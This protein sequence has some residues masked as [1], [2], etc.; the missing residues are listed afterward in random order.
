MSLT[1]MLER[2][3]FDGDRHPLE[4]EVKRQGHNLITLDIL[5]ESRLVDWRNKI[6]AGPVLLHSSI[7]YCKQILQRDHHPGAIASFANFECQ[8][9][10]AHWGSDRY[11]NSSYQILPL[12]ELS[13]RVMNPG[14][15]NSQLFMRTVGSNKGLS[16][17]VYKSEEVANLAYFQRK[18]CIDD[19]SML[20]LFDRVRSIKAEWRLIVSGNDILT[21]SLYKREGEP[22]YEAGY[23]EGVSQLAKHFLAE[24]WQP[25]P[26]YTL[27]ICQS[28]G[29]YWLME[30]NAFSCSALYDC[31]PAPVVERASQIALDIYGELNEQTT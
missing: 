4:D 18:Y 17:A 1:W 7:Q 25:D 15:L 13:R 3:V 23:P 20:I 10:L 27:D 8:A 19:P 29:Q 12:A 16:G 28:G 26:I 31:D 6:P 14:D 22:V 21:G 30:I 2:H 24:S 11:V 5:K 9:W